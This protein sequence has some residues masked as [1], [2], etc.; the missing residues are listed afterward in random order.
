MLS[1]GPIPPCLRWSISQSKE[2][3]PQWAC[4]HMSGIGRQ[5]DRV[6]HV[7][8]LRHCHAG[9]G[10]ASA[11]GC[12]SPEQA[13]PASRTARLATS[14]SES[15][16]PTLSFRYRRCILCQIE[17]CAIH[18]HVEL[19]IF[20]EPAMC[21]QC[22]TRRAVADQAAFTLPLGASRFVGDDASDEVARCGEHVR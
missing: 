17:V 4:D 9:G 20:H 5:M 10:V 3:A 22:G 18:Y 15:D 12:R 7:R 1:N 19:Q 2:T 16:C 6:G 8:A 21:R 13:L 11:M 14:R